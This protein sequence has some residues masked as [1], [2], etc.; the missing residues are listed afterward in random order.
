LTQVFNVEDLPSVA[1]QWDSPET[2]W[3]EAKE[4]KIDALARCSQE[5]RIL[6]Q[7]DTALLVVHVPIVGADVRPV[8]VPRDRKSTVLG[9]ET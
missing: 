4:W 1:R 2:A 5:R 9:L 7:H 8:T 6:T 3:V